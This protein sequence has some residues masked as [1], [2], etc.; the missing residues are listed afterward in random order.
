M[1]QKTLRDN[2]CC[3]TL[4]PNSWDGKNNVVIATKIENP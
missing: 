4:K 1:P 3:P 2:F